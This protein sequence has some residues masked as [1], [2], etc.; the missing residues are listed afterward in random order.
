MVAV[1]HYDVRI[2]S[3]DGEVMVERIVPGNAMTFTFDYV[4]DRSVITFY[5]Y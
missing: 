3:I 2:S 5:S 4:D 1:K